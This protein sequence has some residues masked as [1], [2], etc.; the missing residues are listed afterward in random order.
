MDKVTNLN[1]E[2]EKS[3]EGSPEAGSPAL[4]AQDVGAP[5]VE[6]GHLPNPPWWNRPVNS[7]E[8]FAALV[9]E[10]QAWRAWYITKEAGAPKHQLLADAVICAY[11]A[12]KA[13]AHAQ[14]FAN[15][16]PKARGEEK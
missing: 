12:A 13:M 7:A 15:S 1:P 8:T 14:V 5:C 2:G 10:H 4:R 3:L 9:A 11:Q 6:Y 16:A